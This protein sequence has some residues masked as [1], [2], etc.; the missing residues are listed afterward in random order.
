LQIL[1]SIPGLEQVE[2]MRT[3]YA[4]EYDAVVPTQLLPSL[5]TK[6]VP[7]LFTA[8]Q[9][10]GT[11]GYEEA[12]GQGLIA[13]INAARKVQN[14][15][16]LILDRSDAYIAVMIDDLVTKGTS[17]PYRLLTSRAEY[18]LL[19]RHDNADLRLTDY[20]FD[21][22]LISRER[23]MKFQEKKEIVASEIKRLKS[24]K[25][26]PNEATQTMLKEKGSVI[27]N[28]SVD[29]V[30]LL[31]R[32]EISISDIYRISPPSRSL[33]DDII[34]QIEIQVKYEGYIDKQYA[35]VDRLKKMEKKKL[36]LDLD[37]DRVHGLSN[38]AKQKLKQILPM[39]IGQASRISGVNPADISILLVHL[40]QQ[41]RNLAE[42]TK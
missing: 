24:E 21:I 37:Y 5:E 20:G 42:I 10:N 12:A 23:Y 3:G 2:M 6:L 35:H 26:R 15:E 1:R 8:G 11:S 25:A 7:G 30:Y 34:E 14:K 16:P 41:R 17:E 27:L 4:I 18:R 36:A 9:I 40:E 33:S 38:E 32:P 22:G 31:R 29:W 19:L 28:N 39:S 13:G